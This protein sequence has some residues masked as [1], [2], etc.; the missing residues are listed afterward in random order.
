MT[1][2]VNL[3]LHFSES[4]DWVERSAGLFQRKD[5]SIHAGYQCHPQH[6]TVCTILFMLT[7]LT[8]IL[9]F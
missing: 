1:H 2:K 9:E 6:Y 4:I 8:Q 7:S 3:L 5:G